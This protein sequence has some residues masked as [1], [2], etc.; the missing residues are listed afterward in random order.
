MTALSQAKINV[1]FLSQNISLV[2]GGAVLA[3]AIGYGFASKD[4][5]ANYLASFYGKQYFELGDI[6]K[7]DDVEG[8]VIAIDRAN[9]TLKSADKKIIIPFHTAI[10][11]KI[12]KSN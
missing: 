8:E 6:I 1:E 2:I 5:L 3:F 9:V 11:N 7:V 10:T 12:E 4:I